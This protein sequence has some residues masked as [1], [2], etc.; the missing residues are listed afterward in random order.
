M[1]NDYQAADQG[2][3]RGK[4]PSDDSDHLDK[5][6]AHPQ[7]VILEN[8]IWLYA[9]T[10][11]EE[12]WLT[13]RDMQVEAWC[14]VI[15]FQ[16]NWV[17]IQFL[18][19]SN[20]LDFYWVCKNSITI[21]FIYRL[22]CFT[23]GL[24]PKICGFVTW[25]FLAEAAWWRC[26]IKPFLLWLGD[27]WVASLQNFRKLL[28]NWSFLVPLSKFCSFLRALSRVSSRSLPPKFLELS[29]PTK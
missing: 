14:T 20:L 15:Y 27:K 29:P 16:A 26:A 5:W 22:G 25:S 18:I 8:H 9:K 1:S 24:T 4:Y 19:D 3:F 7:G 2:H 28:I 11:S 13:R 6:A 17:R 12:P 21:H 10:R 23:L